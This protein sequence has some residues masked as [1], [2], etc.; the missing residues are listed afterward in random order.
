MDFLIP[1]NVKTR[2]TF[3]EG[4]GFRELGLTLIG[5]AAGGLLFGL[6][7]VI[8]DSLFSI[9]CIGFGGGLGFVISKPDP[10]TGRSPLE[11]LKSWRAFR[12]KQKKYFYVFGTGR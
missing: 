2:Y 7:Y 10:R 3:F 4:F 6:F 11:L 9:V 5:L 8:T 12:K 1:K